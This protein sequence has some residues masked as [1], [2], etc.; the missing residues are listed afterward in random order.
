MDLEE[1]ADGGDGSW[2]EQGWWG[3]EHPALATTCALK[4]LNVIPN[5]PFSSANRIFQA[6]SGSVDYGTPCS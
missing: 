2:Q 3:C 5:T 4:T 6:D 1:W